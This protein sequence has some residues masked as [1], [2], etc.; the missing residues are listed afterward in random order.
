[1]D[2]STF[3]YRAVG[4]D[5]AELRGSIDARSQDDAL[6][7]L[8]AIGLQQIRFDQ[9]VRRS[10]TRPLSGEDVLAFNQQIAQLAKAGLPLE[11]GL[12]A[13][14]G[15]LSNGRLRDATQALKED[16]ERGIPLEKSIESR[17]STF[18]AG[19]AALIDAGLK[20]GRLPDVLLTVGQHYRLVE[21]LK[22][23]LARS[24]TYPAVMFVAVVA[25]SAFMARYVLA[26]IRELTR[27][28]LWGRRSFAMEY[29]LEGATPN[30]SVPWITNLAVWFGEVMPWV[31]LGLIALLAIAWLFRPLYRG[32]ALWLSARDTFTRIPLAG[33]AIRESLL[34]RWTSVLRIGVDAGM[35]LPRAVALASDAIGSPALRRDGEA[36][37]AS[38]GAEPTLNGPR[39]RFV[40]PLVPL[41]LS[42]ASRTGTLP[43]ALTGLADGFRLQ[44][45]QRSAR[46]P[47]L[48]LPVLIVLLAL[49]VCALIAGL[50][51]PL[52]QMLQLIQG[53]SGGGK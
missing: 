44:A 22:T 23:D 48:L 13:L 52:T 46:L 49:I 25:I 50:F 26:P 43:E 11:R 47:L 40:P 30:E 20:S 31:L 36:I 33:R 21:K 8:S 51:M 45:E 28:S 7:R 10:G 42:T 2:H 6:V 19:Y 29:K 17:R 32:S 53:V 39:L 41:T 24:L 34:A 38:L 3:H 35:D 12:A 27:D 18:P 15:D 1:M 9:P 4:P 14:A 5:D 37:V 16:L